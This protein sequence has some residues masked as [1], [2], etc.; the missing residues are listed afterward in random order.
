MSGQY[1]IVRDSFNRLR[2]EVTDSFAVGVKLL[3]EDHPRRVENNVHAYVVADLRTE[4][5]PWRIRDIRVMW[6]AE[7]E[8]FYIRYRQWKTGKIRE[9]REEWLGVAGPLDRDT[10]SKVQESILAVFFQ[11]KDE[12]A[13]GTL[14]RRRNPTNAQIGDNPEVAAQL[15]HLKTDLEATEASDTAGELGPKTETPEVAVPAKVEQAEAQPAMAA[16]VAAEATE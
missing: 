2:A 10:R 16:V 12:A 4:L 11:I 5:G 1:E 15:E 9:G 8:R 6:S 3:A 14:G 7:N 13:K